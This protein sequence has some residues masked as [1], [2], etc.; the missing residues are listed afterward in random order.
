MP[1]AGGIAL[2]VVG[3]ILRYAVVT[4]TVHGINLHIVGVI[5]MFAGLAGLLLPL[6]GRGTRR[7]NRP[8][9][10]SRQDD[11][12]HVP[13]GYVESRSHDSSLED[14]HRFPDGR[15]PPPGQDPR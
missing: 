9:A 10:R 2:L 15:R 12:D 8:L 1:I 6:L 4:G 14:D 13:Q 3:A 7:S 5:L 11:I